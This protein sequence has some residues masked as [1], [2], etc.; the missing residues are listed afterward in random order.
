[1]SGVPK[2]MA[3]TLRVYRTALPPRAEP[4][5]PRWLGSLLI[6]ASAIAFS[7]AGLF[8][9]LVSADVWTILFWRGVFGGLFIGGYIAWRDRGAAIGAFRSMGHPGLA[10]AACS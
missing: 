9:G 10:A 6:A 7:T 5:A 8:T 1:M 2:G 4:G 3:A